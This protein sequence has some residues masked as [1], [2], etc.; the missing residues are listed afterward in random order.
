MS[1]ESD[2]LLD[3]ISDTDPYPSDEQVFVADGDL[4]VALPSTTTTTTTEIKEDEH[5]LLQS[6]QTPHEDES[7]RNHS[8]VTTTDCQS[9]ELTKLSESND[10]AILFDDIMPSH[11]VETQ[12]SDGHHHTVEGS[13]DEEGGQEIVYKKEMLLHG[14]EGRRRHCLFCSVISVLVIIIILGCVLGTRLAVAGNESGQSKAEDGSTLP[15]NSTNQTT[16]E[17]NP[18]LDG[19][20]TNQS[21]PFSNPIFTPSNVELEE[22]LLEISGTRLSEEGSPQQKAASII[23]NEI[24]KDQF[25]HDKITQRYVMLT[26][27]ASLL[28][29]DHGS[30]VNTTECSWSF[31][32]C[33]SNGT[34]TELAMAHMELMGEIPPE[35]SHVREL[36]KIDFASNNIQGH[37]PDQFFSLTKLQHIFLDN[38]KFSGMLHPS[39]SNMTALHSLYLGNNHFTGTIPGTLPDTLRK[40][41]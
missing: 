8:F 17:E 13:Y 10:S 23:F 19:N 41:I 1:A 29:Q 37:L 11:T 40:L 6:N 18:S 15:S 9:P 39:I 36:T 4:D 27:L 3:L 16:S 28:Q 14:P 25:D 22:L 26:L 34:I 31:A 7:D 24:G 20:G 30:L 32:K 38:N 12:D 5:S 21:S 35:I 2:L 33:D